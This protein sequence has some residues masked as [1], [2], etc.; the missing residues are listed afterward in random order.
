MLNGFLE[1][2]EQLVLQAPTVV[3]CGIAFLGGTIGSFLNVVVY[4]WPRGKS[5]VHPGSRCPQCDHP[6]RWYD[7]LPVVGWIRLRGR[8]R[9]CKAAISVRYPAVEAVTALLFLAQWVADVGWPEANPDTL[10]ADVWLFL[11]HVTFSTVLLGCV[12]VDF[13][14][15]PLPWK[16]ILA[17][18][19]LPLAGLL[20]FPDAFLEELH[21]GAALVAA[22]LSAVAHWRGPL[23]AVAHGGR[24]RWTAYG[25][26]IGWNAGLS[27][28]LLCVGLATLI[29]YVVARRPRR[30]HWTW[31][32]VTAVLAKLPRM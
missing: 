25:A 18:I 30:D 14:R 7:N 12:F 22:V 27:T 3:L 23:G 8:C 11:S 21:V 2:Y 1:T 26:M 6:I 20:L 5:L 17:A 19:P 31:T 32:L 10:R 13:D 9:D 24:A 29:W 16:L 28:S 4:R 15:Q